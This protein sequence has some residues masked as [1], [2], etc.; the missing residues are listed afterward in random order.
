MI[1]LD[2]NYPVENLATMKAARKV[3]CAI[4][5]AL[6]FYAAKAP[7]NASAP[8]WACPAGGGASGAGWFP[9]SLGARGHYE[10]ALA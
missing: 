8:L 4:S 6:D 9:P 10:N 5:D 2:N 7:L 1:R 3:A